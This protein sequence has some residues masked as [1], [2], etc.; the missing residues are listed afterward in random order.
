MNLHVFYYNV[1]YSDTKELERLFL[2]RLVL[3]GGKENF[4][5]FNLGNSLTAFFESGF[6]LAGKTAT[7]DL[8]TLLLCAWY[9]L[10]IAH[11]VNWGLE[12]ADN[13]E[14]SSE[15]GSRPDVLIPDSV[16]SSSTS[17]SSRRH[18]PRAPTPAWPPAP[19]RPAR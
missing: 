11:S 10:K 17:S 5:N 6:G 3:C 16:S 15:L 4:D 7:A 8:L 9:W 14:L 18:K 13:S 12:T 2:F 1:F 19:D